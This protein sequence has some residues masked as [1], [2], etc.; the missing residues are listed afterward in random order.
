MKR[1]TQSRWTARI[2]LVAALASITQIAAA[3][4]YPRAAPPG[5][6]FVR[7]FNASGNPGLSGKIG[8]QSIPSTSPNDASSYV[9]VKPGDQPVSV[10]GQQKNVS[11]GSGK[12]Y[13]LAVTA[14]GMQ[15]FEQDCFNSQLKSLLSVFNLTDG[16]VNVRMADSGTK[17]IEDV[18]ANSS[19]HREV[20]PAQAKLAV[21]NGDSKIGDA[22][23]MQLER[24][25][26]FSLFVTGSGSNPNLVWVV[27]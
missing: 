2:A 14:S 6:A 5:S 24:G 3:G 8:D 17:V 26:V 20:N 27:N 18:S 10:G 19:G 22:K 23:P 25:K 1:F 16:S 4:L 15:P 13:T 9:F 21:Y 11:F 12:C 7:I